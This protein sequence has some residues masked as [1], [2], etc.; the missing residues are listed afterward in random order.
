MTW[1]RFEPPP[2]YGPPWAERTNRKQDTMAHKVFISFHYER[3][4]AR[5]QQVINMNA[6]DEQEILDANEWEKVQRQGDQAIKNWIA[7]QMADK[8]TLLVLVGKETASRKWVDYE[9]R[10]AWNSGKK[11]V[12]VRIHGLKDFSGKPDTAGANP[13]AQIA[14]KTSGHLSDHVTLHSPVGA[15]SQAIYASIKNNLNT[16]LNNAAKMGS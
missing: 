5:V 14:M 3:D 13:F 8:D 9:I 15:D 7:K 1:L 2:P 6:F 4:A 12:G 11:V 10:H 16:W